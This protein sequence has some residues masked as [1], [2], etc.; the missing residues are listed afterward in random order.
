MTT[1]THHIEKIKDAPDKRLDE[2]NTLPSCDMCHAY[3]DA[4]YESDREQYWTEIK[5]IRDAVRVERESAD[6]A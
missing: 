3:L 1:S 6:T 4:L 2:D 5:R